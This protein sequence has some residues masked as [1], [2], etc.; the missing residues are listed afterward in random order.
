[1]LYYCNNNSAT[2]TQMKESLGEGDK[3][4]DTRTKTR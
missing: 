4:K 1:M 2:K 3:R